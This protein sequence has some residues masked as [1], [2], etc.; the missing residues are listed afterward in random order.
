MQFTEQHQAIT[1]VT[2]RLIKDEINPFCEQWEE[3]GVFPAKEVFKKFGD[4]GLLGIAKPQAFG[5]MGLDYSYPWC[6]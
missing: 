6:I 5:G 3:A 2:A 4:L 1:E